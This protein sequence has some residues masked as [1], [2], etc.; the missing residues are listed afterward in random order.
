M[1]DGICEEECDVV[2]VEA[3]D[4]VDIAADVTGG[5]EEYPEAHFREF[6]KFLGK[7]FALDHGGELEFFFDAKD[8]AVESA[9][10]SSGHEEIASEFSYEVLATG[11]G[12]ETEGELGERFGGGADNDFIIHKAVG[13]FAVV[14]SEDNCG[15]G[16]L[17]EAIEQGEEFCVEIGIFH[18]D[19]AG[20][21]F[22]YS[23][24]AVFAER[25]NGG[26]EFDMG[27]FVLFSFVGVLVFVN[28]VGPEFDE[29]S[30]ES[31][32]VD[33]V[34]CVA[35]EGDGKMRH[36]RRSRLAVRSN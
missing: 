32:I 9:L 19:D 11:K 16:E 27:L 7:E 14:F 13:D 33:A 1:S 29:F 21:W 24:P 28:R 12:M 31:G 30:G 36:K 15:N 8:F 34:R 22:A 3:F 17:G 10:A 4:V 20:A 35:E 5:T 26:D 18:G 6:G 25:I 23:G 2:F